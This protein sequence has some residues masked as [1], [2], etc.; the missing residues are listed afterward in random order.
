MEEQK[1]SRSKEISEKYIAFLDRHIDDVV[2]ARTTDLMELN[3]IASELAV[4]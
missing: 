2:A 3:K 4:S 1:K